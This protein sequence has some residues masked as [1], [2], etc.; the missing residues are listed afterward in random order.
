MIL[1]HRVLGTPA[2]SRA[3]IF[4]LNALFSEQK[5]RDSTDQR[6]KLDWE[7]LAVQWHLMASVAVGAEI[8]Q[9]EV[10]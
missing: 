8:T 2:A 7:E 6:S 4:R 5:A 1:H 9:I 3:G 10:T